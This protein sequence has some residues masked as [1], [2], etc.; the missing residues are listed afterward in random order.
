[1]RCVMHRGLLVFGAL[2]LV[3]VLV[4]VVVM[5]QTPSLPAGLSNGMIIQVDGYAI[6]KIEGGKLRHY[7]WEAYVLA[8]KPVPVQKKSADVASVPVGVPMPEK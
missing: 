3:G 4:L 5:A 8:G 7:T 1:M 6:Y 2:A